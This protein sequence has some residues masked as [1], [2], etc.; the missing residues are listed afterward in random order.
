MKKI[1]V[2]ILIALVGLFVGAQLAYCD[3]NVPVSAVIANS[4]PVMTVVMKELTSEGQDPNTGTTVTSMTFGTLTHFLVGGAEAGLWYS[5][6]YYAALIYTSSFG[7][8]YEVRSTCSGLSN[9]A[10][11]LPAGSFGLTPDHQPLDRWVGTDPATAQGAMP[12]GAVL[13]TAGP[14]IAT[15]KSI[16]KSETAAAN[17]ILRGFYSL[18]PYKTGGVAPFT[19]FAPIPLNQAS[20]TYSGTV[21]ITIAAY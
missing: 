8:G 18:P 2:V 9:G 21:A 13:G 17:R 20:G 5:T 16:Y 4:S 3:V 1:R 7:H 19:G 6:K 15:N 11:S 14:A 12:V 10:V